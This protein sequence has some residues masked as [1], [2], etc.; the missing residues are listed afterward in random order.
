MP[1][2]LPYRILQFFDN[3]ISRIL[4]IDLSLARDF[5]PRPLFE[6]FLQMDRADQAHSLR[7]FKALRLEGEEHED[8]L[9]AA[10]LH[11]VGKAIIRPALWQRVLVVL[12]APVVKDR[13][14]D[15]SGLPARGWRKGFVIAAAHPRWGAELVGQAGGSK[16]LVLLIRYHQSNDLNDLPADEVYLVRR[17]Q[18]VDSRH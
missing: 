12:A 9:A 14:Q 6:L 11:D 18:N 16:R 15:M 1:Q 4:P 13:L 5:L 10:L 7:V 8:L 3:L 17:L 2:V